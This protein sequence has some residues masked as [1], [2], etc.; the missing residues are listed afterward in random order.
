MLK[1]GIIAEPVSLAPQQPRWR[2][3]TS[4]WLYVVFLALCSGYLLTE[5]W[6]WRMPASA[7]YGCF[8]SQGSDRTRVPSG[9]RNPAYLIRATHGAVASENEIC[10]KMGVDALK[11]GGNA[12]DATVSTTL[13]IG[14]AN[15]FS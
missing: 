13:C 4:R 7:T 9:T 12:V 10:S 8:S 1:P 2:A 14:V 11:A 3:R 6:S 15:M 5:H